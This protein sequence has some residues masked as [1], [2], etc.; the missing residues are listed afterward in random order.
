MKRKN[1]KR[2]Y[3]KIFTITFNN[4]WGHK[5]LVIVRVMLS[6]NNESIKTLIRIIF[7]NFKYTII[8][9]VCFNKNS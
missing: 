4:F 3:F 6:D 2:N 9:I 7:I 5:F 8:A 1:N